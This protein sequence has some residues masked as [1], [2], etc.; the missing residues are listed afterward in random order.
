MKTC[1]QQWQLKHTCQVVEFPPVAKGHYNQST[2]K[3]AF[4]HIKCIN[5]ALCLLRERAYIVNRNFSYSNNN[6][7]STMVIYTFI[8]KDIKFVKL[9]SGIDC[10]PV[11][12]K[13]LNFD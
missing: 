10:N 3:I 9:K 7:I 8:G 2:N 4:H 11:K 6:K 1:N 5:Q 12:Y 13:T